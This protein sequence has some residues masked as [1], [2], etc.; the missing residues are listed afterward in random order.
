MPTG[1]AV[2]APEALLKAQKLARWL[3]ASIGIPFT[4]WRF[5][6]DTLL[7]LVPV[8]GDVVA[9]IIAARILWLA[10][11]CG[12]PASLLARMLVNVA[13][14]FLL[15]LL[16]VVGDV[17]DIFFKSNQRN[18][19]LLERWWTQQHKMAIDAGTQAALAKWRHGS[20][21]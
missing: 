16:P 1:S 20:D 17:I 10:R 12:A 19:R 13:I 21:S 5:G 9:A 8:I 18:V 7:G 6:A 2:Q 15:G 3:D 14:D 4:P 11:K